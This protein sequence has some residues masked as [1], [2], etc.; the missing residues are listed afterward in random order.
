MIVYKIDEKGDIWLRME[1]LISSINDVTY[2]NGVRSY[3]VGREIADH[4][5]LLV[6]RD[7]NRNG[8]RK[9]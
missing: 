6:L 9:R 2:T 3:P 8:I 4:I 5:E 7:R 1:D